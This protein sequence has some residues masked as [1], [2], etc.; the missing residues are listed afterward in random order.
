MSRNYENEKKWL[1]EKYSRIDARIDK[2]L[3]NQLKAKLKE[4]NISVS[5][6]IT[7]NAQLYLRKEDK[8]KYYEEDIY[9]EKSI[10]ILINKLVLISGNNEEQEELKCGILDFFNRNKYLTEEKAENLYNIVILG[11]WW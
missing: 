6:W 1:K 5:S 8:M 3:G 7:Q 4:N 10:G 11:K 9:K 2:E